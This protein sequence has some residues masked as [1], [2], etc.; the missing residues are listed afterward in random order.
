MECIFLNGSGKESLGNG[1]GMFISKV[2]SP[3][4]FVV[5]EITIASSTEH[6][7]FTFGVMLHGLCS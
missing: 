5:Y 2:S 6:A 1:D 7:D 4:S 3:A